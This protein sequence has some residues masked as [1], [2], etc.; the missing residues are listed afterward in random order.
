MT[1]TLRSALPAAALAVVTAATAASAASADLPTVPD[2]LFGEVAEDPQISVTFEDGTPVTDSTVVHRGDVLL[3]HGT[4]FSTEANRGGFIMPIFPGV[5][6]GVYVLY[7]GFGDDW[8][9]SEGAPGEAR[10]H[11]HDQLAWVMPDSSLEAL[12]GA[13]LDMRTPIARES[14]RMETDGSFTAR[15]V[16]DP[17]AETPGDNFGVY[18]YPAAGS[19]NATEELFIPLAFSD[20]PGANTPATPTSDLV[21]DASVLEQ[22]ATEAGGK[23]APR[24]GAQVLDD[25]RIAFSRVE[26][27]DADGVVRY[28]GTVHATAK[29]SLADIVIK[30]PWITTAADGSRVLSA[31]ISDGY[32]T[33]DDTVTRRDL[34]TLVESDGQTVLVQGPVTL[35]A[36]DIA[37]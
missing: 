25:G 21:L 35:G 29:F 13:P 20:E 32:N 33:S 18:V 23:L 26:G 9:P 2:S 11:P 7:S 37:Q 8:R 5:A 36:V 22:V 31:E 30:D 28:R 27:E 12:P 15:I 19:I 6:N 17:P 10:T 14:Q 4:G 1:F 16:V 24:E 34:G 3:V